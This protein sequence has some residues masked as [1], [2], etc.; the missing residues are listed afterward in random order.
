MRILLDPRVV[1]EEID[2]LAD[3]R[4]WKLVNILPARNERPRQLVF[5]TPENAGLVSFVDDHCID[6]RYV[7]FFAHDAAPV[8]D[9]VRASLATLDLEAVIAMHA[10]PERRARALTY[11]A[12]LSPAS[13]SEPFLGLFSSALASDDAEIQ[14]A[15]MAAARRLSWP[16]L[17]DG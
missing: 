10:E 1:R 11:L 3:A 6:A 16:E 5:A 13:A 17:L 4:G 7:C 14:A 8:A 12:V 2:A 9:V 15:S